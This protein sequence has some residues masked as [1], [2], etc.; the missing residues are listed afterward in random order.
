MK[1]RKTAAPGP[2]VVKG[3]PY[4][5]RNEGKKEYKGTHFFFFLIFFFFFFL[6]ICVLYWT[7]TCARQS[8]RPLSCAFLRL[9]TNVATI[10]HSSIM[11]WVRPTTAVNPKSGPFLAYRN[12]P[13]LNMSY[14]YICLV[15]RIW[16]AG[17][18][19]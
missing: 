6:F 3:G 12:K 14:E 19:L 5:G 8:S 4:G 17:R 11:D 13:F 9:I 7:H 15:V 1:V 2:P 10:R 16:K 18:R